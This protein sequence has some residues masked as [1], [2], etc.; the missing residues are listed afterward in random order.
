M[1]QKNN[2]SMTP[3]CQN[4]KRNTFR[5]ELGVRQFAYDA[6]NVNET[7]RQIITALW[8]DTIR[9]LFVFRSQNEVSTQ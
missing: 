4:A 2:Y 8:N 3:D 5:A 7:M 1:L 9:K 6:T